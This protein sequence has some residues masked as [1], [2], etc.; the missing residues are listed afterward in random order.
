MTTTEPMS[1]ERRRDLYLEQ[2]GRTELT[3]RQRRR[4][5]Q[6]ANRSLRVR[7]TPVVRRVSSPYSMPDVQAAIERF[8]ASVKARA[9]GKGP[10][11][12]RRTR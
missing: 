11:D 5:E 4:A 10:S 9:G 8:A 7:L 12:D 1:G 2:T 3:P 6:K